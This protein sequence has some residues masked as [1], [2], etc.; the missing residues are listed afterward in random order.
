MALGANLICWVLVLILLADS[1]ALG[2][3]CAERALILAH[4]LS[5][6]SLHH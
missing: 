3:L 1:Q 5:A 6:G 2:I 4:L